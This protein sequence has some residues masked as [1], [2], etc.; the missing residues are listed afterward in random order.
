MIPPGLKIIGLAYIKLTL[1]AEVKKL[2][3]KIYVPILLSIINPHN[4]CFTK[5]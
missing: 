3:S 5:I 1:I 4:L 2:K